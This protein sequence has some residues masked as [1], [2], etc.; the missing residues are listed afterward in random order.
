MCRFFCA[1]AS[2]SN[3]TCGE[4]C[5]VEGEPCESRKCCNGLQCKIPSDTRYASYCTKV[6]YPTNSFSCG[7]KDN[8]DECLALQDIYKSVTIR[9]GTRLKWGNG[10]TYC[11]WDRI[12]CN[13]DGRIKELH[14]QRDE[15][16]WEETLEGSFSES[17]GK[18][19]YLTDLLASDQQFS[20]TIP[21]S[22]GN[23]NLSRLMLSMN[24]F[25]GQIPSSLGKLN[26]RVLEV[27]DNR[28]SNVE[29]E[30][31]EGITSE[32]I[33]EF[34]GNPFICPLPK[35]IEEKCEGT[36]RPSSMEISPTLV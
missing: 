25:T 8:T 31:C 15:E 22:L 5:S 12:I 26:F 19:Q 21:A 23:T 30:I 24:H 14:F 34:D 9:D 10:T 20:G 27:F 4:N 1:V 36:C 28:F 3:V 17:F 7:P 29:A 33:C 32:T 11:S 13:D 2:V 6:N 35:C 16:Y 18:L